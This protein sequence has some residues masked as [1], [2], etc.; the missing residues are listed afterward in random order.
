MSLIKTLKDKNNNTVE[1]YANITQHDKNYKNDLMN[2]WLKNKW[3]KTFIDENYSIEVYCYTKNGC[4][5]WYNPTIKM[6]D[7]SKR[8]VINFD[9][10]LK[11]NTNNLNKIIKAVEYMIDKDIKILKN[12]EVIYEN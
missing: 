4:Y 8:L 3:V 2:I 10:M 5:A 11:A 7:D 1:I 6:S 9:Y 12:D